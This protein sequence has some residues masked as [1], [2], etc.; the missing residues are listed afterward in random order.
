M[1]QSLLQI[2]QKAQAQLDSIMPGKVQVKLEKNPAT[3]K[4]EL[5]GYYMDRG[6]VNFKR[7]QLMGDWIGCLDLFFSYFNNR[8]EYIMSSAEKQQEYFDAGIHPQ[9]IKLITLD[10]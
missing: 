5:V 6:S 7:E 9:M 10:C 2:A 4:N 8:K 3:G 1:T